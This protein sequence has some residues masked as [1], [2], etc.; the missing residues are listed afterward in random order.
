MMRRFA[1]ATAIASLVFSGCDRGGEDAS[2]SG[3]FTSVPS[4]SVPVPS[5]TFSPSASPATPT[6][7]SEPVATRG[8]P[9]PSCIEG[10]RAPARDTPLFTDPLGIIRR[11]APVDGEFV[12]VDMRMFVGPESPPS[13]DKGY[14]QDIRRWYI[15]L[16]VPSDRRYAGRFLVESRLFGRGVAA[17][18]PYDSVGF[19][20]PDWVGFQWDTT[21]TQA[22]AYPGYPG[23]WQGVPYDFVRGGAGLEIPGLPD[24]VMGCLDGT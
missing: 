24:E 5:D 15:K 7:P 1:T 18:A 6:P 9:S 16:Y 20:S 12:V 11:T 23:R 13:P 14:L 3:G 8:A 4:S 2:N 22:K 19:S 21:D 17:V 10:W